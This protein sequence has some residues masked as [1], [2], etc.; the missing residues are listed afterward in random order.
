MARP[1]AKLDRLEQAEEVA[2]RLKSESRGIYRERLMA[3]SH[4][5]K[6]ELGL[7]AI[8]DLL[9]RSR[10]TIQTWF[11][12]Y[13]R[14]GVERLCGR[15]ETKTGPKS[16]LHE[17]A[18]QELQKKLAKGSFRR[19]ADAQEWLRKRFGIEAKA[20]TV[21]AWMGKLGARL[22]V[23]RPRHPNSSEAKKAEFREQ[24][25]RKLLGALNEKGSDFRNRP[26][27]IW[28]ADEARFGLQPCHRRAWVS[29]GVRATKDS[30]I[31]Y[32]WQYLRAALQIGGGGSEYLYSN[33]ADGEVSVCFLEQISRRD[34]YAIHAV[35]WDGASFHPREGD[36]RIPGNVVLLRQPPYRPELNP[37]ERL[38]DMLRD[39]L[40]N[41]SWNSLEHLLEQAPRWLKEFWSDPRRICSL[42]G[43]GW[44]LHQV[45]VWF[46]PFIPV[47]P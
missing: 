11:D 16:R 23:V 14:E 19:G 7:Q 26:L 10:A 45:N 30:S 13:R 6:G 31:R 18:R 44:M 35:I 28:A 41:R 12:W 9:G 4:G 2:L 34:P 25:A 40:C 29:Q 1:R 8:A 32:D 5:L 3:V 39:G 38:W 46:A 17:Q 21:R 24:L 43:E 37:V 36:P 47:K 42:I 33:K 22:K 20:V 15:S 27:R